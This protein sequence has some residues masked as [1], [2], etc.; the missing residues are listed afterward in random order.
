MSITKSIATSFFSLFLFFVQYIHAQNEFVVRNHL[1]SGSY[2]DN[3][4]NCIV[5]GPDS[6]YYIASN[7][8]D[9]KRIFSKINKS[10]IT[11]WNKKYITTGVY[12][13]EPMK[14]IYTSDNRLLMAGR[15]SR[16]FCQFL[17]TAGN[18][19]SG[20]TFTSPTGAGYGCDIKEHNKR[21]YIVSGNEIIKLD[22]TGN[23]VMRK[24]VNSGVQGLTNIHFISESKMILTGT[25]IDLMSV[26]SGYDL[27]Q[28]CIDTSGTISWIKI[29]GNESSE[30]QYESYYLDDHVFTIFEQEGNFFILKTDILGNQIWCKRMNGSFC[31]GTIGYDGEIVVL[32]Q[33]NILRFSTTTGDLIS[34]HKM[35]GLSLVEP[36]NQSGIIK[37]L[38]GGYFLTG[39]LGGAKIYIKMKDDLTISCYPPQHLDLPIQSQMTLQE[40]KIWRAAS[41]DN[42]ATITN[43]L[44]SQITP[45]ANI[46][47]V[48]CLPACN[49]KASI[50]NSK[51][52]LC[53]GEQASLYTSN[54][55]QATKTWYVNGTPIQPFDTNLVLSNLSPGI[56]KIKLLV[57]NGSCS[58]SAFANLRVSVTPDSEFSFVSKD[59][60]FW[61]NPQNV[62][63]SKVEWNFG[64]ASIIK[65]TP[66]STVHNY[67]K[68]GQ[69]NVC[70]KMSNVCGITETCH[71][72]IASPDSSHAFLKHYNEDHYYNGNRYGLTALQLAD[73][74]YIFDGIDDSY[75][76]TGWAGTYIKTNPAGKPIQT[77]V[78]EIGGDNIKMG[79]MI[80]TYD[81]TI[82]FGAYNGAS[83]Y[84]GFVDS[85]GTSGYFYRFPYSGAG[86]YTVNPIEL[87]NSDIIFTGS[88][89]DKTY[90]MHT[91][92]S[93]NI[94]WYKTYSCIRLVQ[95]VF[96]L[97][98]GYLMIGTNL[99]NN[100]LSILKTDFDGNYLYSKEITS[101][102]ITRSTC[103]EM[104]EDGNII[105]GAYSKVGAT[106]YPSAVKIKPD[107]TVLWSKYFVTL[108][109]APYVKGISEHDNGQLMISVSDDI[110]QHGVLLLD[111]SGNVMSSWK[112]GY[113]IT[114]HI[115][116]GDGGALITGTNYEVF[117]LVEYEMTLNKLR[118][119]SLMKTCDQSAVTYTSVP[120]SFSVSANVTTVDSIIPPFTKNYSCTDYASM[121]MV[122]CKSSNTLRTVDFTFN[123]CINP[124]NQIQF[125]PFINFQIDSILWNFSG[126][127]VSQQMGLNP[128]A[129]WDIVG[130]YTVTMTVYFQGNNT[131]QLTKNISVIPPLTLTVSN[132]QTICHGSSVQISAA[133][134]GEIRW[135][136]FQANIY[137]NTSTITLQPQVST[138]YIVRLT[139]NSG[140]EIEDTVH[141]IVNH[142][143]VN[144]GSDHDLCTDGPLSITGASSDPNAFWTTTAGTAIS[145]SLSLQVTI[146]SDTTFILRGTSNGCTSSD[147]V[148]VNIKER[149][150]S[151]SNKEVCGGT[152]VCL[153]ELNGFNFIIQ[154]AMT[155]TT[156]SGT[157]CFTPLQ[158]E[159]FIIEF[160]DQDGCI[161]K[162]TFNVMLNHV[163][164]INI[165]SPIQACY[166]I[167]KTIYYNSDIDVN[168]LSW[169]SNVGFMDISED[170]FILVAQYTG[171]ITV[172]GSN[173]ICSTQKIIPVTVSPNVTHNEFFR[174][175]SGESININ[176]TNYSQAG[177]YSETFTTPN[178]C[179][180][181]LEF[182][183]EIIQGGTDYIFIC[184]GESFHWQDGNYDLPGIYSKIYQSAAGCDSTVTLNL[185]F[186][187]I[188]TLSIDP[189]ISICSGDDA[190]FH[191][192]AT[193][194]LT[195]L[196]SSA[197]VQ[198]IDTVITISTLTNTEVTILSSGY[199][200]SVQQTIYIQVNQP[201]SADIY[202]TICEGDFINING[203]NYS[204]AGNFS[205]QLVGTNGCDST[206]N[207]HVTQINNVLEIHD[208]TCFGIPYLWHGSQ[209][210]FS[211]TYEYIF[212]NQN[213]C[214]STH[215]LHLLVKP[216]IETQVVQ[217]DAS[218]TALG[219]AESYT[220]INCMNNN[221]VGNTSSFHA[222]SVGNYA[223]IL[224]VSGCQ[225]TSQCFLVDDLGLGSNN[226]ESGIS[227]YPNPFSEKIYLQINSPLDCVMEIMD[228]TGRMINRQIITNVLT[229]IDLSNQANG[230]YFIH[231]HNLNFTAKIIKKD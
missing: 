109:T 183:I 219:V 100:G 49:L 44:S 131:V 103:A 93:F 87:P 79:P 189:N 91:S 74:G 135:N 185:K 75:G 121:E 212:G 89:Q 23:V 130:N 55:P 37:T 122:E 126:A 227:I 186:L 196:P 218:L 85:S 146:N 222:T 95:K 173:G 19:L 136:H 34:A 68:N 54:E 72:I 175:C 78:F 24:Q 224:S 26:R 9:D 56:H 111:Q 133:G 217:Q 156:Q 179:D 187:P 207:I 15:G 141:I 162:D 86:A 200:N 25:S 163:P 90:I 226:L 12:S 138:S 209:Y 57:T 205:Q 169:Q 42:N 168:E 18:I 105:I 142:P 176:G 64:D 10:G 71:D 33:M 170:S 191:A 35:T 50:Q 139:G 221:P 194:D 213:M 125:T 108:H 83:P 16:F 2:F 116:T 199:C 193:G 51:A 45:L 39:R 208:T 137:L 140:C 30:N 127:T 149:P 214:D 230:S 158:N 107:G 101:S 43:Y 53:S 117:N 155:L 201:Q 166:G 46:N 188:A 172:S 65:V 178:G 84:F 96:K 204:H 80:E 70:L 113:Q 161:W 182:Y 81:G 52:V 147:T 216:Q 177:F 151:V 180:S 123:P 77:K 215:I 14:I 99:T 157:K 132:D 88:L 164:Q 104:L 60:K 115:K 112:P 211:G 165:P 38:D 62:T 198:I 47:T 58:D 203:I 61:F 202:H 31:S 21:Y 184:P 229:E 41:L 98:D 143:Y 228:L 206:L 159:T 106:T 152:A 210:T 114:S 153:P 7:S 66:D 40:R 8:A 128:L 220:W 195:W 129:L 22:S 102:S 145:N 97:N 13:E 174:I 29:L 225:D 3:R 32:D 28:V 73:G 171:T 124:G 192:T 59:R 4:A 150:V 5:Q 190:I 76:S 17:D 160:P 119:D 36:T 63:D 11:L 82:V 67:Q 48:H 27:T 154:P 92:K 1:T 223:V 148:H 181:I 197:S 94:K 6:S 134:T 110:N 120:L 69:Y 144:A 20:K 167:E 231:I 118:P